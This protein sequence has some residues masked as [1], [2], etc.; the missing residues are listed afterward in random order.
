MELT[1]SMA[2]GSPPY[3]AGPVPAEAA[4]VGNLFSAVYS[5]SKDSVRLGNLALVA[6]TNVLAEVTN[7]PDLSAEAIKELMDTSVREN[8]PAAQP[9]DL[10]AIKQV[11][12]EVAA[13]DNVTLAD[14]IV[15]RI[16]TRV[17]N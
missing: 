17:A 3:F 14:D 13:E 9:V 2:G 4:K 16:A 6:L 8:A 7:N 12:R 11:V 5:Y 1:D 10:E 15:D